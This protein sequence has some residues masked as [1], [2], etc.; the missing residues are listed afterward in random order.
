MSFEAEISGDYAIFDGAESVTLASKTS[1]G[2]TPQ[3]VA[4]ALRMAV[5]RS[6]LVYA[7]LLGMEQQTTVWNLPVSKCGGVVPKNGD[8]ITDSGGTVWTID[9]VD[10]RTRNSRY[11]CVCVR[12]R[13]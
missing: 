2:S 5:R 9:S 1:S 11:R 8:S 6:E 4:G 7:G 10:L 12:E 13:G 3:S